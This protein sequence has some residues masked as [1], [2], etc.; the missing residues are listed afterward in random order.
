[1]GRAREEEKKEEEQGLIA[2]RRSASKAVGLQVWL[3]GLLDCARSA[4]AARSASMIMAS[5]GT[6]LKGGE[7]SKGRQAGVRQW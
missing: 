4:A 6:S 7:E 1:M 5:I 3:Q 2:G